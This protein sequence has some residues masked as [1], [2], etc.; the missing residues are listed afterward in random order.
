MP[1]F[2]L[3][4]YESDAGTVH[5]VKVQPSTI[6]AWNAAPTA[7]YNAPQVRVSGGKRRIGIKCRSVA[8]AQN[9][10]AAVNGFQPIRVIRVPVLDPTAFEALDIGET[11]TYN[12]TSWRVYGKTKESG[13][14]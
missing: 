2:V 7:A 10:G 1:S 12:T 5:P 13:R 4:K 11:V 8:L 9:I 3:S 14:V 6:T